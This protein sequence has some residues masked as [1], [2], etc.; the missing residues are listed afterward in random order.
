[1]KL[2]IK[3]KIFSWFDSYNVYD[4]NRTIVYTVKGR[5][6]WGHKLVIY[7]ACGNEIGMVKEAVLTWMPKFVLYER[8]KCV[9]EIKKK[10][11]L[12]RPKY[13]IDHKNWTAVGNFVEWDYTVNS[14]SGRVATVCKK[15]LN[16]TDTYVIDVDD[17]ADALCCLM[18]AL[19]IDA[20]K[21]SREKN[22]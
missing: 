11:S 4:E 8:G 5:I 14:P 6:A 2:C 18:F 17:P 13:A 7:D 3:Q 21:C 15:L 9:G 12:F 19:A 1:M 22:D 20:E 16:L 10:I